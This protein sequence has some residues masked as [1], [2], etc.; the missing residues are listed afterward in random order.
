LKHKLAAHSLSRR[1]VAPRVG[2]WIETEI[3]IH[4]LLEREVAPRVGAWIETPT[5]TP[6]FFA[7]VSRPP[8]GG[9]D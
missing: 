6:Y 8:R 7:A 5:S 2:A 3:C 4:P 1:R 9:V